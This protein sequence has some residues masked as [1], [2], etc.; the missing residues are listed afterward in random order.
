[1]A[2]G[3]ER[4]GDGEP[5]VATWLVADVESGS[6]MKACFHTLLPRGRRRGRRRSSILKQWCSAVRCGEADAS[7]QNMRN[8]SP[9]DSKIISASSASRGDRAKSR[10]AL[11]QSSAFRASWAVI[12]ASSN[13][14]V[15]A[16]K[17]R[18]L[19]HVNNYQYRGLFSEIS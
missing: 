4:R 1:M 12:V 3:I 9:T 10:E 8:N 6:G 16:I 13:S 14:N 15:G 18:K 5:C 17:S 7:R 2:V 11:N 19:L